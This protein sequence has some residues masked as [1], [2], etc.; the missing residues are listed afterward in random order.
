METSV[1]IKSYFV[2]RS[3]G[4]IESI[5][6]KLGVVF[7]KQKKRHRNF[8]NRDDLDY[9]YHDAKEIYKKRLVEVSPRKLGDPDEAA[10]QLNELWNKI[11]KR[12]KDNYFCRSLT[13][14]VFKKRGLSAAVP[15]YIPIPKVDRKCVICGNP[16]KGAPR[17]VYDSED[18]R[19]A[20]DRLYHKRLYARK[21]A[22]NGKTVRQYKSRKQV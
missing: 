21:A 20:A 3:P 19:R 4:H 16:F 5:L 12:F 1:P 15:V 10:K 8:W 14:D 11:E 9:I 7:P 6:K 22:K 13:H 2:G 18:C 17:D